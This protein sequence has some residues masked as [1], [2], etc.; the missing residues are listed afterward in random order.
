MTIVIIVKQ[1]TQHNG[2]PIV[3][4]YNATCMFALDWNVFH[5]IKCE[6]HQAS[7]SLHSRLPLSFLVLVVSL[8]RIALISILKE[9]KYN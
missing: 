5:M 2:I 1:F 8:T 9:K 7:I 4:N 6:M 3:I